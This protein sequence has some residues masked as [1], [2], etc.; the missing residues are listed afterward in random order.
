MSLDDSQEED[1]TVYIEELKSDNPSLKVNAASK[2]TVIAGV[3]GHNRIRDELVPY[4]VEIIEQMDNENEFLIKI[5][6]G[7]HQLKIYCKEPSQSFILIPPLKILA[8]LDQPSVREKA[9][10]S[11][12]KI[13]EGL[14]PAFYQSYIFPLIVEMSDK[15]KPYSPRVSA[16]M[17][18]PS[19]YKEV[20]QKEKIELQKIFKRLGVDENS[21]LVRRAVAENIE[22]YTR[23]VPKDVSKTDVLE[24]WQ[25]F[26]VDKIDI[27]RIK[28]LETSAVMARFFKKE[29][30]NEKFFKY[31]KLVDPEKKSWRIRY[32]LIEA[33]SSLLPYL[34]KDLIKK[35]SVEIF[36]AILNDT[37]A[38][39][40]TI[41]IL[42][43]PELAQKLS[44]QQSFNVFFPYAEKLSKDVS[45]NVRLALVENI[46]R[47]FAT[48][49][50]DKL[51]DK[52]I[53]LLMD[54]MKEDA[55]SVRIAVVQKLKDLC[56]VF[57]E[58]NTE[59]YLLPMVEKYITEKKWRFKLA[60]AESI[61]GLFKSL[62]AIKHK[63]FMDK[64]VK[65]YIKD[66]Y[67]AVREQTI[68]SIAELKNVFGNERL[69]EI[70]GGSLKELLNEG[71]CVYRVTAC[72]S[73]KVASGVLENADFNELFSF[74]CKAW[75]I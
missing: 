10:E 51:A 40:R 15:K 9:V 74:F 43:M 28:A 42:K 53:T 70:L 26:I 23:V 2:L 33:V 34:E 6:E 47:Y 49:E 62:D 56:E 55:P 18:I 29:E 19:C 57:G 3:L 36:E 58:E 12:L 72:Q 4:L 48:L 63:P 20:G 5:A 32:A 46:D 22:E 17:M 69:N 37:E 60:V 1:C 54:L 75:F 16:S 14:E 39:V 73:L 7:L 24:I 52:G 13:S 21:P 59:K 67:H 31:I 65:T 64:V 35:D 50:E 8:S 41:A 45:I 30:I 71:N 66:H 25:K 61:K 27:V 11:I 44:A 38:E 68:N